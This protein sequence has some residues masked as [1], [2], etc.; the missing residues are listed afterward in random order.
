MY[1]NNSISFTTSIVMLA[2]IFIPISM[3]SVGVSEATEFE[4]VITVEKTWTKM[5]CSG[6]GK[7]Y[8]RYLVRASYGE[9]FEI[10][11]SLYRG[12]FRSSD[13]WSQMSPGETYRIQGD[14]YRFGCTSSYRRIYS[15]NLVN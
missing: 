8:E 5:N 1:R 9:V 7:C 13:L 10:T 14:G 2:M 11:D 15:A 12:Q 6:E 4:D 3:C